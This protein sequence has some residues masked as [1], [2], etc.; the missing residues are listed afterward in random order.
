MSFVAGEVALGGAWLAIRQV[1]ASKWNDRAVLSMR[2]AG[3]PHDA[4]QVRKG[5]ASSASTSK[6]MW[7]N[8]R[9]FRPIPLLSTRKG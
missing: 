3:L 1:W 4:L 2:K 8:S 9:G 6:V 5:A 7:L